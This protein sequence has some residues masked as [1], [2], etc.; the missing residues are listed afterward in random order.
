[1]KKPHHTTDAGPKPAEGSRD[2]E[3]EGSD[4]AQLASLKRREEVIRRFFEE[5]ARILTKNEVRRGQVAEVKRWLYAPMDERGYFKVLEVANAVAASRDQVPLAS[6]EWERERAAVILQIADA[7]REGFFDNLGGVVHPKHVE[8][9][10]PLQSEYFRVAAAEYSDP[11][12]RQF[13]ADQI[14]PTCITR[15]GAAAFLEKEG[16]PWPADWG[17]CPS[18]ESAIPIEPP[19][20]KQAAAVEAA[21]KEVQPATGSDTRKA[22]PLLKEDVDQAYKARITEG[23][24]PTLA[25]DEA[26]RRQKGLSR[27]RMRRLRAAHRDQGLKKGGRPKPRL[28]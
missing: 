22:A 18:A 14:E 5:Q 10:K 7:I 17:A 25:E 2:S 28:P 27:D 23:R 12:D 26:W 16:D 20:V 8:P 19:P 6:D 21:V 15:E 3:D 13:L 1:M 4:K 24:Y 9:L 11:T